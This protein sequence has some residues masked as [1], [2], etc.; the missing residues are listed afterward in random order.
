MKIVP[1]CLVEIEYEVLDADGELV[2]SNEEGDALRFVVGDDDVPEKL[3][4]AL[5]G[6]CVGDEFEV[7]FGPGEIYEEYNPDG[8]V[9]VPRETI[10]ED[11]D[12]TPGQWIVVHLE[13]ADLDDEE[14][15]EMEMRVVEV[16]GDAVVL[17][18]NHP[19]AGQPV[20]FRVKVRDVRER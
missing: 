5:H 2:E 12:L 16:D 19:L 17:D 1:N 7:A 6:K 3:T 4:A 15:S 10:E 18:A 8:I 20:T 13:G 11:V 14:D 9:S